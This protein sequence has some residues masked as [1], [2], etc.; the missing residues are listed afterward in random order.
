M[1]KRIFYLQILMEVLLIT[2]LAGLLIALLLPMLPIGATEGADSLLQALLLAL[3]VSPLL[4]WRASR[5]QPLAANPPSAAT[6]SIRF[7]SAGILLAGLLLTAAGTLEL[8]RRI[9]REAAA[10]YDKLHERL[11]A[12]VRRR[13]ALPEYGLRG[14]ANAI[15]ASDGAMLTA[16]RFQAFIQGMLLP[17]AFPGVTGF[18][19]IDAVPAQAL[20][21]YQHTQQTQAPLFR[22]RGTGEQALHYIVRYIEPR[23]DNRDMWGRDLAADPV[24]LAALQQATAHR[25][26]TMSGVMSFRQRGQAYPGYLI[27]QAL[28]LPVGARQSA[29]PYPAFVYSAVSLPVL[30]QGIRDVAEQQLD[31]ELYDSPLPTPG[32][33]VYDADSHL[34]GGSNS[35]PATARHFHREQQLGIGTRSLTL[36]SSS[37]RQFEASLQRTPVWIV[38][39]LGV[40]IS[41]LAALSS[42]LVLRSQQRAQH[43]AASMTRDLGLLARVAEHTTN[44][45]IITD[46]Q[47][48]I[49]WV[50]EGF[51]RL[52]GYRLQDVQG[53]SPGKLLQTEATDPDTIHR[54]SQTLDAG[55]P[56]K[57]NILNRSKHGR[58]YWITMEIQPLLDAQQQ[59]EGF[60]AIETD[61]SLQVATEAELHRALLEART[62]RDIIQQHF[63]VSI[64][65]PQGHI[66][67]I[68]Q[69]FTDIS[70]YQQH[71]LAGR[72]HRMLNAGVHPP[73]FWQEM[74][75]TLQSGKAW[76]GEVCNR[77][78]DGSVY[79][80]D[81]IIVP[82][83]NPDGHIEQYVSIRRDITASKR[84]EASLQEA[85]QQAE[86]ASQ[87]K[88]RF[89]ANM[90]HEIRTPMKIF[91]KSR[92]IK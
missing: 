14:A 17:S 36:R 31:F 75:A 24:G 68:N 67:R 64:A 91:P 37:S 72:N 61:I 78:K 28:P 63:I 70:G 21:G 71:E 45:I 55:L 54:L 16:E 38:A 77:R 32:T 1:Q 30:M 89:L 92:P 8:D 82:F 41:L 80:V 12:E 58:D 49:S 52:T 48:R 39:C 74:W 5:R 9:Q 57:G 69:A 87:A 53:L 13:F 3:L 19:L 4:A 42:I 85:K 11:V 27:L 26:V 83:L 56:F 23:T 73:A 81:S 76:R 66:L 46:K 50:N 29:T 86:Q 90:S 79:W 84:H 35:Y 33:L 25:G 10:R 40:I 65:D 7:A 59:L 88:S 20:A 47:R 15:A 60:M 2:T 34:S 62:I 43:L 51:T 6:T 18:G 22:L 44:A